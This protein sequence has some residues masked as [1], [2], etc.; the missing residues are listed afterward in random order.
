MD[1]EASWVASWAASWVASWAASWVASWVAPWV[2]S[3]LSAVVAFCLL[4]PPA[5]AAAVVRAQWNLVLA[6]H[7]GQSW[8]HHWAGAAQHLKAENGRVHWSRAE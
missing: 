7:V 3:F 4:P 6:A 5:V 1:E 2:A 8:S